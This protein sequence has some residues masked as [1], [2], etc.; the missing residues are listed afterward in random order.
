MI[1]LWLPEPQIYD[2]T[3]VCSLHKPG[4]CEV[5]AVSLVFHFNLPAASQAGTTSCRNDL[6]GDVE[7]WGVRVHEQ[8]GRSS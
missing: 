2:R 8:R 4:R 3:L 5:Q 7:G 6:L 1:L